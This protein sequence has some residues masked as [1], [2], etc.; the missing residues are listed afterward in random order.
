M[1]EFLKQIPSLVEDGLGI[2]TGMILIQLIATAILFF[3]VYKVLWKPI[4]NL[5]E[6]RREM[7]DSEIEDARKVNEDAQKIKEELEENLLSAKTEAKSIIDASRVRGE[8]ERVRIIEDAEHEAVSL[9]RKAEEEIER[10]IAVA[11]QNL[12]EEIVDVAYQ[13]AEKI[14]EKE[15]DKKAHN[16][17]VEDVLE[18]RYDAK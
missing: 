2:D 10:E 17:V 15:V 8:N 9:V 6:E 7:I 3:A 18:G 11:R 1:E 4:T 16:K 5:L 13:M 12:K 14:V